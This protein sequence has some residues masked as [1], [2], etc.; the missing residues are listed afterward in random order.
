M[1]SAARKYNNRSSEQAFLVWPWLAISHRALK[2]KWRTLRGSTLSSWMSPGPH[3]TWKST[4][5]P[6]SSMKH[7]RFF[8]AFRAPDS[9]GSYSKVPRRAHMSYLHNES[10]FSPASTCL[11]LFWSC[12]L[13]DWRSSVPRVIIYRPTSLGLFMPLC[14]SVAFHN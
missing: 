9:W 10:F 4:R 7:V 2:S 3:S 11:M 13:F 5:T 1:A 14:L 12:T 6:S 8:S